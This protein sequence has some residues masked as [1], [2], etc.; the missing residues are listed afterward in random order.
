MPRIGR[1]RGGSKDHR[2]WI[3]LGGVV[4]VA[5]VAIFGIV[6]FEFPSAGAAHTFATPNKIAGTCYTNNPK[7]AKSANLASLATKMTAKG[8]GTDPVYG[9]YESTC[10]STAATGTQI[11]SVIEAHLAN[12]SVSGS[13]G[14]FQHDY[15]SSQVVSA[16]SLGGEAACVQ[17]ASNNTAMCVWFDNDSYGTLL[18]TTMDAKALSSVL[19]QFR[20]AVEL[21]AK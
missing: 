9:A 15:P 11:V 13:I 20:P 18:S 7:I 2:L 5:V 10:G 8:G 21:P 19:L 3:G 6:K 1:R 16:G 4:V 14:A 12:D 17:E